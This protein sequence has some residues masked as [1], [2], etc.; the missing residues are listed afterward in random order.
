M[1]FV[2]FILLFPMMV[3]V[4]INSVIITEKDTIVNTILVKAILPKEKSKNSSYYLEEIGVRWKKAT[5][6]N[7]DSNLFIGNER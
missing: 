1:K 4:K 7:N 3:I 6:E 5:L 2:F